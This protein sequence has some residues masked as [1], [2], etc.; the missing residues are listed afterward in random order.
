M[1]GRL[2]CRGERGYRGELA[3]RG[4]RCLS[5]RIG[6]GISLVEPQMNA[7]KGGTADKRS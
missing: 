2:A 3:C 6:F 7:E 4:G 1:Q 5:S